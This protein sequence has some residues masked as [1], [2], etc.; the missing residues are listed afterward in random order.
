MTGP[1]IRAFVE[2]GPRG[3]E[4]ATIEPAP[5]GAPPHRVDLLDPAAA[6]VAGQGVPLPPA[7]RHASTYGLAPPG[8]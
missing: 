7:Q 2:D 5:D 8:R 1:Q 4:Q 3:G 6:D